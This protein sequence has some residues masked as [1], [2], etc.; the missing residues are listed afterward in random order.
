MQYL[1]DL[2]AKVAHR[3]LDLLVSRFRQP[4][5]SRSRRSGRRGGVYSLARE[6]EKITDRPSVMARAIEQ[7]NPGR[8]SA[9]KGGVLIL[10][11][12]TL[13]ITIVSKCTA[14]AIGWEIECNTD[15]DLADEPCFRDLSGV[16]V[17]IGRS[18]SADRCYSWPR[19]H[20]L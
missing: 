11:M 17:S 16:V 5:F 13:G 20:A 6:A 19:R 2:D 7:P 10:M 3:A 4:E 12:Q 9:D 14:T 8:N 15:C 1:V 18:H